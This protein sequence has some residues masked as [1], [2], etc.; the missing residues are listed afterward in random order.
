MRIEIKA[1]CLLA[2]AGAGFPALAQGA[3]FQFEVISIRPVQYAPG[4]T[5]GIPNPAPNGF[6]TTAAAW[7]LLDFAYGSPSDA[8]SAMAWQIT[9]MRNEPGWVHEQFYAIDARVSATDRQAW[10]SQSPRTHDLLRLALRSMLQTRFRLAIH[11]EPAKRTIFELMVTKR[12]A[13]LKPADLKA[14]LPVGV[15]LSSGGV[16]T[17]IG[18]RGENGW[19]FHAATMQDFADMMIQIY[20]DGP[21]RDGTGLTGRYDFQARRIPTPGENHGF[22][23]DVASLGLELKRGSENR[24]ILVIDRIEKPTGN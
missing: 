10:Q 3:S 1:L 8:W 4:M 2:A 9:E 22:A 12:G 14:S 20:F 24:P 17:G 19:D 15:K 5:I 7:Q 11:E 6:T 18:P 21:V 13:R 16:A 23:Y